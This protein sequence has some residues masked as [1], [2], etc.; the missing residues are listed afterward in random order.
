MPTDLNK[1]PITTMKSLASNGAFAP[2][3]GTPAWM[4]DEL[5]EILPEEQ[6]LHRAI[7]LIAFAS[8]ASFYRLIPKV[9]V[10]PRN[11]EQIQLL[12]QY[13]QKR[14]IPMTFRAGGTSLS[15]QAVSDGILVETKRFWQGMRVEE[16]GSNELTQTSLP[17]QL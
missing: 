10:F 9:V 11:I 4:L 6:I 12:F 15:G 7:D 16:E 13:S 3:K 8:D 14:G 17:Y 1:T 5:K 2:A